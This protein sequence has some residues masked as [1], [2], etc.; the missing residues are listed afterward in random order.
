MNNIFSFA[1]ILFIPFLFVGA[2]LGLL[3]YSGQKELKREIKA[4]KDTLAKIQSKVFPKEKGVNGK[5]DTIVPLKEQ[6]LTTGQVPVKKEEPVGE[7]EIVLKKEEIPPDVEKKETGKEE[8]PVKE[9]K[10][11]K[12]QGE[13]FEK[14][15]KSF[16][17]NWTGIIGAIIIVVGIGF[18]GIFA[19]INLS[20]MYRFFMI[21]IIS[22]ACLICYFFLRKNPKWRKLG[23]WVRSIAAALFLLACVGAGGIDGLDWIEIPLYSLIVLCLGIAANLLLAIVG[24][25]QVIASIHLLLSLT[26]L[27]IAPQTLVI[28]II[29]TI[30]TLC[31][32]ILTFREKWEYQLLLTTTL[33]CAYFIFYYFTMGSHGIGMVMKITCISGISVVSILALF[34]HYRK[35][36]THPSFDVKPFLTHIF[37]W[38]YFGI[39]IYLYTPRVPWISLPLG[40][41]ACLCFI[42]AHRA[43]TLK[44]R[45][46]FNT[47]ILMSQVIAVIA[48]ITLLEWNVPYSPIICILVIE[49]LVFTTIVLIEGEELLYH[50]GQW[51]FYFFSLLLI[52]LGFIDL[53]GQ[54]T[55]VLFRN[56]LLLSICIVATVFYL[57]ISNRFL[58]QKIA[59]EKTSTFN[60]QFFQAHKILCGAFAGLFFIQLYVNFRHR[61][62]WVAFIDAEYLLL[63]PLCVIILIRAKIQSEGLGISIL[64][65]LSVMHILVW[66]DPMLSGQSLWYEKLIFSLPL[67]ILDFA[68][69][70]FSFVKPLNRHLKWPGIYLFSAHLFCVTA[71]IFNPFSPL[72]PG[73]VWLILSVLMLEVSCFFRRK[74]GDGCVQKGSPD[75]HFLNAGYAFIGAFLVFGYILVCIQ[76]KETLWIFKARLLIEIF[77]LLVFLYWAFSKKPEGEKI[78]KSYTYLHPLFPELIMIFAILTIAVEVRHTY[79]PVVWILFSIAA[80][81]LGTRFRQTLSRFRLHSLFLYWVS[82]VHVAFLTSPLVTPSLRFLDLTWFVS[83]LAIFIQFGYIVFFYKKGDIAAVQLPRPLLWLEHFTRVVEKRKNLWIYYPI[84]T[85]IALFLIWSFDASILTLLLSA[86]CFFIFVI[87]IILKESH[88]RYLSLAGLGLCMIRLAF[89]DLAAQN[90]LTKAI[91]CIGVGLLLI[92]MNALYNKFSGRFAK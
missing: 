92:G 24:K 91:V 80:L 87:S 37:T 40:A 32:I 67:F 12:R 42:L 73:V 76:S 25:K 28:F 90:I 88:F 63:I 45:W 65:V 8:I 68:C 52:I 7:K 58:N 18:L 55:T 17:E 35:V 79:H 47:D 30:I 50:S 86:E 53:A 78:S 3:A 74:Y 14:V 70:I 83:V 64:A 19:A 39:G 61:L 66:L 54:E 59:D 69:I 29:A 81:L 51:F 31:G 41:G 4:L 57:I 89:Y 5:K 15:E 16:L 36:Y 33:Y 82:I 75:V 11:E 1:S 38:I 34:V 46:L 23:L 77:A 71:Y 72:I 56:S 27:I 60:R 84:F 9:S 22:L 62:P 13:F 2:L 20:H 10:R 43:R 49:S 6:P 48:I 26:A 21:V 85:S 44:I